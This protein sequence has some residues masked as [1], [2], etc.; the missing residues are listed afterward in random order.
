MVMPLRLRQGPIA[1][2]PIFVVEP[3]LNAALALG[4]RLPKRPAAF[5]RSADPLECC[6]VNT[7]KP[8]ELG[9]GD[10]VREKLSKEPCKIYRVKRNENLTVLAE[11]FYGSA[12]SSR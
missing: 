5:G 4:A 11:R 12:L 9:V 1:W 10:A 8:E 3:A 2:R 7:L 6:K